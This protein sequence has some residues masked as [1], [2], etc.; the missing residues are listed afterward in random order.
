MHVKTVKSLKCRSKYSQ[1]ITSGTWPAK[2]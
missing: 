1:K 2:Q